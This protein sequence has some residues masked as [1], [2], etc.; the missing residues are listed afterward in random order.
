MLNNSLVRYLNDLRIFDTQ[1]Y[2]W[3]LIEF[4]E[5]DDISPF[6]TDV[7]QKAATAKST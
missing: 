5:T 3:T 2:K 6:L 1:K 7:F 4:K